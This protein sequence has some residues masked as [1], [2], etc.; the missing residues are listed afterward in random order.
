MQGL[1]SKNCNFEKLK[2]VKT[3]TQYFRVTTWQNFTKICF[4]ISYFPKFLFPPS[5]PV[6]KIWY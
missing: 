4:E 3:F 1:G 6:T 5:N 2:N